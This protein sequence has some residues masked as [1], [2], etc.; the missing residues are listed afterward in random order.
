[1]GDYW[2]T[3]AGLLAVATAT[4]VAAGTVGAGEGAAAPVAS[5]VDTVGHGPEQSNFVP[6]LRYSVQRPNVAPPGANDFSCSPAGSRN[7]VVLVHG[8][9]EN[10]YSN[11]AGLSPV[12]KRAGYCVFALNY[13]HEAGSR[14]FMNG[15]APIARSAEQFDGYVNRV[16]AATGASK[17]DVVA[18]SQGGPLVRQ[19]MKFEGG[20]DADA[21]S[22]NRIDRLITLGATNNG[23]TLS[24]AVPFIKVLLDA[25]ETEADKRESS[26]ARDQNAGSPFMRRLN[27]GRRVYP[28]VQ[29]TIVGSRYDQVS[30]PYRATFLPAGQ[31]VRN[32]TLQ[33]GCGV[34]RSDHSS[35]SYSPRAHSIV[36]NALDGERFPTLV[37]AENG[38]I[39]TF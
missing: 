19:W 38:W 15:T 37:C 21:P 31:N 32:V 6:A 36:L 24:G 25:K 10:A 20:A 28:G 29:Y 5:I 13:G 9:W 23:T 8:T 26:A 11:W 3:S 39:H 2:K 12:L 30:T 27:S 14:P 33:D 7:P 17:V 18:H 35:I 16:L 1:M 4:V 22:N 34:D